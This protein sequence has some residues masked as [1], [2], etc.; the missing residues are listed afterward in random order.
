MEI[1]KVK[2][3]EDGG[4]ACGPCGGSI[5]VELQVQDGEFNRFVLVSRMVEY[6]KV[7]IFGES[8]IESFINADADDIVDIMEEYK[9][10]ELKQ[11]KQN[12]SELL[13]IIDGGLK[14]FEAQK[15]PKKKKS[16]NSL[17]GKKQPE[18]NEVE[19]IEKKYLFSSLI[20]TH[21]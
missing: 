4:V 12:K 11:L 20:R 21:F 9:T 16:D 10:G 14:A 8:K 15:K 3:D 6:E 19:E 5:Y 13:K 18:K 1:I 2:I 7:E 17:L